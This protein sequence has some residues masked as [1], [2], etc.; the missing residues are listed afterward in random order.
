MRRL[1]FSLLAIGS[2]TVAYCRSYDDV[3]S[4][5]AAAPDSC[6][7]KVWWFHGEGATTHEGITADLEAYKAAG[8]GGVVYYDQVHGDGQGAFEEMSPE[9]WDA[10]KFAAQ[11]AKRLGLSFEINMGNGYVASGP[12]ITMEQSM[13]CVCWSET[14]AEPG[15]EFRSVWLAKPHNRQF[16]DIAVLAI[17]VEDGMYET[18]PSDASFG[19]YTDTAA[20]IYESEKPITVRSITYTATG[21]QKGH[22]SI[23]QEPGEPRFTFYG[24]SYIDQPPIGDL[25]Y[26]SDGRI[27]H[28]ACRLQPEYKMESLLKGN[29]CSFPAITGR[30]FRIRI[31]DWKDE[32]SKDKM[33]RKMSVSNI[34]LSARARTDRWEERA[35]F[36][37]EFND[38][39]T[40]PAYSGKEVIN[41]AKMLNISDALD[42]KGRFTWT[43]PADSKYLILRFAYRS[44]RGQTK[45][46]RKG[47]LGMECDK[48]DREAAICQWT[49]FP[50]AIIDTL[51]ALGCKPEGVI[52]DS[53]E[54]G[55]QN[56]TAKFPALYAAKY[57]EDIIPWLPA[58]AGWV[59]SSPVATNDFLHRFRRTIADAMSHEYLATMDSLARLNGVI[60]TSQAMGNGQA[61]CSDNIAA[62][63]FVQKA[64][65]E[66]WARCRNGVY[67]IKEA[68]SAAHLYNHTVASAEAYTDANYGQ[69]LDFLRSEADM[70]MMM[71][72]NEMVVCASAYQPQV[73]ARPDLPYDISIAPGNVANGRQYCL[74]R[75]N[76]YWRDSRG[77]WDYQ[78]R[79]QYILRQGH[80][81]VDVLVYAGDQAPS[82]LFA[83]TLPAIPDGYDFDVCTTEPLLTR[84]APAKIT[85]YD[86][87]KRTV[88][89]TPDGMVYR[90]LMIQRNAVV[91]EAVQTKLKEWR[92]AGVP[93][94]DVRT[95]KGKDA[96]DY[97]LTALQLEKAKLTPDYTVTSD[98][99]GY[100]R[101][102]RMDRD[103]KVWDKVYAVHRH[104]DD[105][106]YYIVVNHSLNLFSGTIT[107]RTPFT[108]I[109]WWDMQTGR[110]EAFNGQLALMP[111][112]ACVLVAHNGPAPAARHCTREKAFPVKGVWSVYFSSTNG[113]PKAPQVW[114]ELTDW[115]KS[116]NDSIRYYS[117]TATYI[118]RFRA[119]ELVG[120][121]TYLRATKPGQLAHVYVNNHDCGIIWSAPW[122][123]LIGPYLR[124]GENSLRIEVTG[125]L[126]NRLIYDAGLPENQRLTHIE[127]N[128]S[129]RLYKADDRLTPSGLLDPVE[130]VVKY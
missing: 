19:T 50:Q 101:R 96:L 31:H 12:W 75:M 51:S 106:D 10:L 129:R 103:G 127:G 61:A 109:D 119:D 25:E 70:S 45:H 111:N 115:T 100:A 4:A 80:A 118:L 102:R 113:G 79:G 16:W 112:E 17:P 5:F 3:Y 57:H 126:R 48:M 13:K 59:V 123:V 52:M 53:H 93:V 8:V 67:D 32:R 94:Y 122:D 81:V 33:D 77:F 105:A 11:E 88:L 68:S 110:R 24:N 107:L 36:V 85:D 71:Q 27:W 39:C 14:L 9:W 95:V 38:G 6:R 121:N 69:S 35:A 15:E 21:L 47:A 29:T 30:F 125:T 37:T 18:Y 43:A 28:K 114:T 66:F 26:S 62:K 86:G 78:A 34:T 65:G 98:D 97:D 83:Y 120:T 87:T 72:V 99:E 23:L 55:A 22:Q 89:T 63:G 42:V 1:I 128:L 76:P 40:T 130:L 58:I 73:S 60:L 49:H 44:T 117:G 56:W 2:L 84:L 116:K 74:N 92:K 82:K 7:T 90:I 64:Q 91:P 46:G 41:P 54:A 104:T 124:P 20:L 108:T